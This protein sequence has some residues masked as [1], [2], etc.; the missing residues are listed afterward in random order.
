MKRL[1]ANIY[2][3]LFWKIMAFKYKLKIES[4]NVNR[5]AILR[6][7]NIIRKGVVIGSDVTIGR[8]TYISGPGA[9]VNSGKIGK[10]CSIAM[11]VKIGMDDHDYKCVST[12]PFLFSE[13]FGNFVASSGSKQLKEP[14]VIGNDVWIGVDAIVCRGVKVSD[15][16]IVAAGAVVTKDVAPY[17]I[18]AGV[19]AKMIGSRF[20]NKTLNELQKI[21]WYEWSDE[22][23]KSK[24]EYFYDVEE[25]L[26]RHS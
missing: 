16:A 1:L 21:R 11:G 22:V 23:I 10:F 14:P 26:N 7:N 25:F 13:K 6:G 9:V 4:S 19:P 17:T 8:Y 12:H 24:L 15:G 2:T 3:F 18:V 20:D 5:T